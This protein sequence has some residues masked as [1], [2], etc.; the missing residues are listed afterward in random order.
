MR[1]RKARCGGVW[2]D[3]FLPWT[4]TYRLLGF[5]ERKGFRTAHIA[6][7]AQYDVEG[8]SGVGSGEF[9]V[10]GS[11]EDTGEIYFAPDEG[12]VV[13][14]SITSKIAETKTEGGELIRLWLN[15]QTSVFLTARGQRTFPLKW[16]SEKTISFELASQR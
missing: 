15:P 10:D 14:A 8:N 2:Q 12:I 13:E 9:Y 16:R 11:G 5:A 6:F 1:R 7:D 3:G 4:I